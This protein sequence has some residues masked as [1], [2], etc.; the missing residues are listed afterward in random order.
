[1]WPFSRKNHKTDDKKNDS[2]HS[3]KIWINGLAKKAFT[4]SSKILFENM[5][6]QEKKDFLK[7][8]AKDFSKNFTDDMVALANE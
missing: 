7:K 5:T 3:S 8:G 2:T 6:P 1:M 4:H